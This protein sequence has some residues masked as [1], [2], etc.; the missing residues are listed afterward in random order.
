M[1]AHPFGVAG[2]TLN[3]LGALGLLKFT[4]NPD[5]GS[6]L[7]GDGTLRALRKTMPKLRWWYARLI[8]AYR[9]SLAALAL[10]FILQLVDLLSA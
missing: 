6:E 2:L 1:I 9:L 4:A 5:A 8:W 3:T 7:D 10:G